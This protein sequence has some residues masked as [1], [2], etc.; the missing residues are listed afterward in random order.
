[1]GC[2]AQKKK[3]KKI[4]LSKR[5]LWNRK[6]I[7]RNI[8]CRAALCYMQE[9]CTR[10]NIEILMRIGI[11][12]KQTVN[13]WDLRGLSKW[14]KWAVC[15]HF[16][17]SIP[18]EGHVAFFFFCIKFRLLFLPVDTVNKPICIVIMDAADICPNNNSVFGGVCDK[19]LRTLRPAF[20]NFCSNS[21]TRFILIE[22]FYKQANIYIK[23]HIYTSCAG[24]ESTWIRLRSFC[25]CVHEH[26]SDSS[27]SASWH[28]LLG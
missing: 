7:D 2:P 12:N 19:V 21:S 6:K 14:G 11:R 17:Y 25:F 18:M 28:P 16:R 8:K 23:I 3:E 15:Q 20:E 1:M 10:K 26:F 13:Y 5:K 4:E 24:G 22:A 27:P 9:T